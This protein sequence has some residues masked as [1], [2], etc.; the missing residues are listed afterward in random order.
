MDIYDQATEREEQ[1]RALASQQRRP[2]G[3]EATGLCHNCGEPLGGGAR[4][5]DAE[6]LRDWQARQR[7]AG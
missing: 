7:A 1:D 6:C 4:W 5:C 3:P 2:E